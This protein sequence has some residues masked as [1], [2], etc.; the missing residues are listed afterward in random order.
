MSLGAMSRTAAQLWAQLTISCNVS[1][2]VKSITF[3]AA[4][5]PLLKMFIAVSAIV[6]LHLLKSARTTVRAKTL[7]GG[8]C[9]YDDYD[10]YA[11]C[12]KG[13]RAC[14]SDSS[15]EHVTTRQSG[16]LLSKA[17]TLAG[18]N[19]QNLLKASDNE[20][21]ESARQISRT[22]CSHWLLQQLLRARRDSRS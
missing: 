7:H 22:A 20:S 4:S 17:L 12:P 13:Y 19:G 2:Y 16:M 10:C 9:R 5:L 21:F 14:C 11:E 18:A 8:G 1:T 6:R 3:R 15:P